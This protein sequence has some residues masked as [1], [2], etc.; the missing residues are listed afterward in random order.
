MAIKPLEGKF[1]RIG[2]HT[3]IRGLG[4][5]NGKAEFIADG[6]VGQL[7]AREAAYIV[8]QMIKKGKMAGRAV[9]L[10]G[11]PGTGK[12]AIAL[13]I[14]KE[15]GKDV[16]FISL[17]GSEIYSTELKKTEILMRAIRR[18]IGVRL[19]EVR[20]VIEG[21]VKKIEYKMSPHP[22]NPYQQ[23]PESITLTLATDKEEKRFTAGTEVAMSFLQQN[24][25]EGDIV[26]IDRE[27]GR[28]TKLGRSRNAPKTYD[29]EGE[30]YINPP[31]G[32]LIKEREFV[33]TLSLHELDLNRARRGETVLSLFFGGEREDITNEVRQEVDEIVKRW[34]EEGRAEMI[35]G[36]LFIDEIHMLD[37]EAFA[38]LNRALESEMAPIIIFAS[39]RGITRIRGTDINSPHGIPIDFLDRILIISTDPYTEEEIRE[40]LKLKIREEKI[41]IDEEAFEELVRLGVENSLRY[42]LIL[43][44][45]LR[46]IASISGNSKISKE[47]VDR[48]SQL[49]LDYRKSVDVVKKY[50]KLF[51]S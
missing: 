12:T 43:L 32:P 2:F 10:A 26:L 1:E 13:A 22:Y 39:N 18:A 16:P 49:F 5:R 38:F 27:T 20:E 7:R 19:K 51:L 46:E 31:E 14:A 29:I 11:P 40:I 23:I 8:V 35:P 15:L 6:M 9:L 33:Y 42:S 34:I 30:V 44:G 37:I 50:E 41:D 45:P 36:V 48:A 4:V 28:T 3:H 21:E 17:S 24:I 25:R 47:D